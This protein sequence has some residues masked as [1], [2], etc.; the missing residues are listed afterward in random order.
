MIK[1]TRVFS[2][3]FCSI[4]MRVQT[5]RNT[6]VNCLGLNISAGQ[7]DD[8]I[9]NELSSDEATFSKQLMDSKFR[10]Y[11]YMIQLNNE[12]EKLY[13]TLLGGTLYFFKV[14]FLF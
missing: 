11:F 4:G 10:A 13:T 9:S 7:T 6:K 12:V 1:T 2:K 3:N 5:K 14:N 8:W